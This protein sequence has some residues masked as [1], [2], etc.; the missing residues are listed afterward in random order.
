LGIFEVRFLTVTEDHPDLQ[1]QF[2]SLSHFYKEASKVSSNIVPAFYFFKIAYN[3]NRVFEVEEFMGEKFID[4][5]ARM[6][7]AHQK[8]IQSKQL[9]NT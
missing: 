7:L 5:L 1:N 9:N 4:K 3:C 2:Q 6:H 8:I